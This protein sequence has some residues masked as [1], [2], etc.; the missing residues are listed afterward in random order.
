MKGEKKE[1]DRE[2]RRREGG[3]GGE[4]DMIWN[5]YKTQINHDR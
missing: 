1:D 2:R 3:G 5:E 4:R